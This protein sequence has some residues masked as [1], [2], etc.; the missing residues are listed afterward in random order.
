ML[1]KTLSPNVYL[2]TQSVSKVIVVQPKEGVRDKF[3]VS[4]VCDDNKWTNVFES[5]NKEDCLT[6][7]ENELKPKF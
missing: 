5:G 7:I 3:A 4:C 6:F 1:I 2:N